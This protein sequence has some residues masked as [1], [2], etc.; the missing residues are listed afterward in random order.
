MRPCLD[1]GTNLSSLC[2]R[3]SHPKEAIEATGHPHLE[4]VKRHSGLEDKSFHKLSPEI[5]ASPESQEFPTT[6]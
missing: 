1:R 4:V 3:S 5:R 2:L 6:V